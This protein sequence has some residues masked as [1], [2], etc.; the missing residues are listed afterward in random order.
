MSTQSTNTTSNNTNTT[1]LLKPEEAQSFEELISFCEHEKSEIQI[2]AL[3]HLLSTFKNHHSPYIKYLRYHSRLMEKCMRILVTVIERS[4]PFVVATSAQKLTTTTPVAT[5]TKTT[6]ITALNPSTTQKAQSS[7]KDSSQES[8]NTLTQQQVIHIN[9]CKLALSCLIL[10][11]QDE[12]TLLLNEMVK[13]NIIEILMN[14]SQLFDIES[15]A[16]SSTLNTSSTRKNPSN[17]TTSTIMEYVVLLLSNLTSSS[18]LARLKFLQMD[19]NLTRKRVQKMSLSSESSD[20]S[21]SDS[22]SS[23][24]DDDD[25]NDKLNSSLRDLYIRKLMNYFMNG[26]ETFS[27]QHSTVTHS[28]L[29]LQYSYLIPTILANLA[30]NDHAKHAMILSSS[31]HLNHSSH[32]HTLLFHNRNINLFKSFDIHED[33]CMRRRA[34][35]SLL[36]NCLFDKK[37]IRSILLYQTFDHSIHEHDQDGDE[38]DSRRD[39]V[40]DLILYQLT[41][42]L[43]PSYIR[44]LAAECLVLITNTPFGVEYLKSNYL[45]KIKELKKSNISSQSGGDSRILGATTSSSTT[46]NITTNTTT[47]ITTNITTNTNTTTNTTSTMSSSSSNSEHLQLLDQVIQSIENRNMIRLGSLVR[48]DEN[49]QMINV[50]STHTTSKST[51]TTTNDDNDHHHHHHH[52]HQTTPSENPQQEYPQEPPS[53]SLNDL[54]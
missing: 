18:E 11:S 32:L 2:T 27:Q 8:N 19:G 41:Y 3:S 14:K 34:I 31:Q 30:V 24:S 7:K 45:T 4:I 6:T 12:S 52:H 13:N 29:S 54:D 26:L 42:H 5:S 53:S 15:C 49:G 37:N 36:K 21:T 16:H 51:T 17:N 25:E 23:S 20:D 35:L 44:V 50:D 43:F 47:N 48:V 38:S 33:Q 28:S 46:T 10:L 40:M 22:S 39:L 1:T 9:T